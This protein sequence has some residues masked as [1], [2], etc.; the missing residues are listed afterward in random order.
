MTH[1]VH[2]SAIN[3]D[4]SGFVAAVHRHVAELQAWAR[5]EKLAREKKADPYPAPTARPDVDQAVRRGDDGTFVADF[6]IV[7][8]GPT[9]EQT[10][11][12]RKNALI[13]EVARL[14]QGALDAAWPPGSRRH[15]ALLEQDAQRKEKKTK[16]DRRFLDEMEAR[17]HAV[18]SIQRQAAA[19]QHEVEGLT[20]ETVDGWRAKPFKT[21]DAE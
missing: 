12:A 1:K 3:R 14:E 6:E 8:D 19:M 9:P 18:A 16:E 13:N 7:D 10:L 21:E 15:H 20:A 2:L 5:Q 17:R 4:G 11:R